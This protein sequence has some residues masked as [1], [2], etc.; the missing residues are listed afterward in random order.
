LKKKF[1]EFTKPK[2]SGV[3]YPGALHMQIK[4]YSFP[5][6]K[7]SLLFASLFLASFGLFAQP[8]KTI[9]KDDLKALVS[10]GGE[11]IRV[12]NFWA[13]WCAPC[14][15]E[16]PLFEKLTSSGRTD[17]EVILISMDLE[18]DP[19]PQ[20]VF[21]FIERKKLKSQVLLLNAPDPNSWINSIEPQWSG[22]LPA[23]IIFNPANGKRRFISG[24]LHEGDLE[25]FVEEI[26]S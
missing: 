9:S 21:K 23:T 16:M 13:T 20:K 25:K 8:A 11:K 5:K 22:A 7:K 3:C 26:K 4:L 17:T 18:L 19:N 1:L 14:V 10:K 15:K 2:G 6:M 12:I 24:E